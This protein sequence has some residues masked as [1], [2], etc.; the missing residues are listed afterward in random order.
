MKD[1]LKFRGKYFLILCILSIASYGF[2][3]FIISSS[4]S[5]QVVLPKASVGV[6]PVSSSSLEQTLSDRKIMYQLFSGGMV[7]DGAPTSVSG[8]LVEMQSKAFN[9]QVFWYL[10]TPKVF[11]NGALKEDFEDIKAVAKAG[12]VVDLDQKKQLQKVLGADFWR[13]LLT[14]IQVQ[15]PEGNYVQQWVTS[16]KS[17]YGTVDSAYKRLS[18]N[19]NDLDSAKTSF[20]KTYVFMP[21]PQ[22][23][24]TLSCQGDWDHGQSVILKLDCQEFL[25]FSGS[26]GQTR[27]S[28]EISLKM[29]KILPLNASDLDRM[30]KM[31]SYA[32]SISDQPRKFEAQK[33]LL[34]GKS[35]DDVLTL[36]DQTG[37]NERDADAYLNLKAWIYVHQDQLDDIY[38]QL[39]HLTRNDPKFRLGLRA[40]MGVGSKETQLVLTQLLNDSL[41]GDKTKA[42]SVIG[43][44]ALVKRPIIESEQRLKDLSKSHEDPMIKKSS[45]L[46]LG[47][48][49]QKLSQGGSSEQD[50][51]RQIL[52]EFTSQLQN[53]KS[54]QQIIDILAA[55]GNIGTEDTLE[56]LLPYIKSENADIASAALFSLRLIPSAASFDLLFAAR[57]RPQSQVRMKAAKALGFHSLGAEELKLI[58]RWLQED[59]DLLV[60]R[61][62]F[63]NLSDYMK[64]QAD[65]IT[66]LITLAIEVEKDPNMKAQMTKLIVSS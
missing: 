45:T 52:G 36:V 38:N 41:V 63:I 60:R 22:M 40:L 23:E 58:G 43:A 11:S 24:V 32:S 55:L 30:T 8:Q 53:A 64:K 47:A 65:L 16:E 25:V 27:I 12:A 51:Y 50:R 3:A 46:A 21:Q 42:Q 6:S 2:Y 13:H 26:K 7:N 54:P 29:Q 31:T 10:D 39:T 59:K 4:E 5:K 44:M 33:K 61:Q 66:D 57:T 35:L 20:E 14:K 18:L 15:P 37:G 34:D 62:L 48:M 19:K 28:N 49:G 56:L 17:A 1:A 9:S